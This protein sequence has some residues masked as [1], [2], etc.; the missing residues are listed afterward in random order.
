VASQA[1]PWGPGRVL[2]R[3]IGYGALWGAV[4]GAAFISVVIVGGVIAD[5]DLKTIG[6]VLVYPPFAAIPGALVGAVAGTAASLALV[7]AGPN[8]GRDRR[9]SRIVGGAGAGVP[10]VVAIVVAAAAAVSSVALWAGLAAVA[11]V[12]VL[13]GA[14]LAP[15]VAMGKAAGRPLS[16]GVR[17]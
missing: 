10:G 13:A 7:L 6:A 8:V 16:T 9:R 15:R 4:L 11:F 1:P 14:A 3:G 17:A 5:G 12:A 2:S